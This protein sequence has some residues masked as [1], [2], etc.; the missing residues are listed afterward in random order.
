MPIE[1]V[2]QSAA[3]G[4]QAALPSQG[5]V[6][7]ADVITGGEHRSVG[8]DMSDT[9]SWLR[10]QSP[11][12]RQLA[13]SAPASR[14]GPSAVKL[15]SGSAARTPPASAVASPPSPPPS[16]GFMAVI[17]PEVPSPPSP[18][19]SSAIDPDVSS[20]P[21]ASAPPASAPLWPGC[22]AVIDPDVPSFPPSSVCIAAVESEV[23]QCVTPSNKQLMCSQRG[24]FQGAFGLITSP[25]SM[26]DI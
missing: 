8:Q 2:L 13:A 24:P 10:G 25:S 19:P 18:P 17:D 23:P 15:A 5:V 3:H 6:S 9:H 4:L 1:E 21:P 26:R 11:A 14:A 22:T 20:P 12:L 7:Q 16:S